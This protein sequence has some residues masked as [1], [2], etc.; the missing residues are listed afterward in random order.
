[1]RNQMAG[2]ILWEHLPMLRS[3]FNKKMIEKLESR[4]AANIEL[5]SENDVTLFQKFCNIYGHACQY[6]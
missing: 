6:L 1:M 5:K 2:H 3:I 4:K